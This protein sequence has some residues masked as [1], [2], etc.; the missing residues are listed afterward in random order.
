[1]GLRSAN[2]PILDSDGYVT[3]IVTSAVFGKGVDTRKR[4]RDDVDT[5]EY[6]R[7]ELSLAVEGTAGLIPMTVYTGTALNGILEYSG[8]GKTR[9]PVYNRVSTLALNLGFATPD[10]LEG[11][12]PESVTSRIQESLLNLEG[13]KVLFKLGKVEGKHLMVPIPD[14]IRRVE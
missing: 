10:E 5:V 1:M 7:F 14:T 11:T 6:E 3:A 9:K 2:R 8:R 12:I 4:A 13:E